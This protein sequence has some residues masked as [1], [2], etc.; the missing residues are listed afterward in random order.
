MN[1]SDSEIGKIKEDNLSLA[2]LRRHVVNL[3]PKL[4]EGSVARMPVLEFKR[5]FNPF[6]FVM[7]LDFSVD[8][9]KR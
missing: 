5:R 3:I 4:Y 8:Y 6:I 7:V 2:L 9:G 1:H